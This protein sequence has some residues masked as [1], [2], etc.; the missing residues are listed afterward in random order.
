MD[1]KKSEMLTTIADLF[2]RLGIRSVNMDDIAKALK[3]SKKTLYK[4]FQDKQDVVTSVVTAKCQFEEV[5]VSE[6]V[7]NS[8]N[9]IDELI[10]IS[11]FAQ[12]QLKEI[13]PSVLY[14]LEKYYFEAWEKL[15]Q[16]KTCFLLKC[17]EANL[18]RGKK[19]K[20]YRENLNPEIVA[21][22]YASQMD[23][24][25]HPGDFPESK[26]GVNDIHIEIMRYHIRGI[27][28]DDGIKYLKQ[29]IQQDLSNL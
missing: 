13:H 21:K 8:E 27:A 7:V 5:L 18:Y 2:M 20:L 3:I 4:Y 1:S 6:I 28:N 10:Q 22:I 15:Q 25:F 14:D 12:S 26:Y 17:I 24:V 23:V 16:H 29:K 19:E 11:S 9:A